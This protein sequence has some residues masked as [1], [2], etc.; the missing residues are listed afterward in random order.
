VKI[1]VIDNHPVIRQGLISIL[2]NE[3]NIEEIK[4]A[5]NIEEAM[6]I[7]TKEDI[8]IAI[9]DLRLGTEDGLAIVSRAKAMYLKTKFIV[10][11]EVMLEKD[12]KRGEQLGV[13]GYLLKEA[14]IED[15]V[16]AIRVIMRG[17][18]YYYSELL[19]YDEHFNDS[20]I[21]K[22]TDREK[23][24]LNEIKKGLSN[25]E[26]ANKL[27]ISEHTVKKHVSSIL[28]KLNLN[29]RTQIAFKLNNKSNKT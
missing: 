10:L 5:S 29:N 20:V 18:R 8:E 19:K 7:I 15:I 4:E 6:S 14:F 16:Y 13:E 11:T 22:L 12:F 21:N 23:D 9:I 2:N 27:R 26:I 3:K 28:T 24:V 25:E 17:K 1:V